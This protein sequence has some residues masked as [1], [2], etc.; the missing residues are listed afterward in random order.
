MWAVPTTLQFAMHYYLNSRLI[1]G[2]NLKAKEGRNNVEKKSLALTC[3]ACIQALGHPS[4][5]ATAG[6]PSRLIIGCNQKT[7]KG[8]NRVEKKSLGP[9]CFAYIQALGHPSGKATPG[10]N[11][12]LTE[13]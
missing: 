12:D 3:F 10:R 8:K 11:L 13:P 6:S 4:G 1:I 2:C 9:T 7:V 5:K